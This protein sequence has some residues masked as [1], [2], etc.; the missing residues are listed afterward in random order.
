VLETLNMSPGRYQ[1][2]GR[3]VAGSGTLRLEE[4]SKK[5]YGFFV[6]AQFSGTVR[7]RHVLH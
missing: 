3:D 7:D 5:G 6:T 2:S 4:V 1:K